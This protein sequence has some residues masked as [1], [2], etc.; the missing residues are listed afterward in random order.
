MQSGV[1]TQYRGGSHRG[2]IQKSESHLNEQDKLQKQI[3]DEEQAHLTV[4][5]G[6]LRAMKAALEE[7]G[8]PQQPVAEF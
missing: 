8:Y 1:T 7:K 4:T 5:H 2:T 3:F 6:K